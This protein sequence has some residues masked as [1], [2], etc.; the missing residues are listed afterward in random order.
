MLTWTA[1]PTLTRAQAR[2]AAVSYNKTL[3]AMRVPVD[4]DKTSLSTSLDDYLKAFNAKFSA[5]KG[6]KIFRVSWPEIASAKLDV[7]YK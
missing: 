1:I 6:L 5:S 7:Y 4:G 2:E 3:T